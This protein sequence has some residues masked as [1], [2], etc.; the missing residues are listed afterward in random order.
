MHSKYRSSDLTMN[1][2]SFMPTLIKRIGVILLVTSTLVYSLAVFAQEPSSVQ[3]D[4]SSKPELETG[5][6]SM[7]N[8][9]IDEELARTQILSGVTTLADPVQPGHMVIWG[10]TAYSIANNNGEDH[11][12]PMIAAAGFGTGRVIAMGDHQFLTMDSFGDTA[13]SGQLYKNG[14]AWLADDSSKSIKI[15]VTS[16][17]A[18]ETWLAA[19]GYTNVVKIDGAQT[20]ATELGDA[21]VLVG[22]LGSSVAQADLDLIENFVTG[23]GGLFLSLIHI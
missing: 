10:D 23:G 22:W 6:L 5:L 14:I 11:R 4:Q 8:Q 7:V 12:S 18:A 19:Q 2:F 21:D 20:Y 9:D 17:T 15:V 3:L 16:G 1:Y 13:D